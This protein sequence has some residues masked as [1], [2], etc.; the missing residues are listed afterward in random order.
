M[1]REHL[2]KMLALKHVRNINKKRFAHYKYYTGKIWGLSQN[3]D[4][5]LDAG[6]LGDDEIVAIIKQYI[7]FSKKIQK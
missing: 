2:D 7:E 5:C 3:Y 6:K 1:Q 4:L